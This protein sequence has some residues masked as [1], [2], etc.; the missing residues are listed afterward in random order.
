[1][2]SR[3]LA[4]DLFANTVQRY[5]EESKLMFAAIFTACINILLQICYTKG[6]LQYTRIAVAFARF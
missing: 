1:M 3:R 6:G 5:L 2:F 4:S